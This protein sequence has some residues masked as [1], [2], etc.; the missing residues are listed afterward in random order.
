MIMPIFNKRGV[1]TLFVGG[2]HKLRWQDEVGGTGNVNFT[3]IFSHNSKLKEFLHKCQ[4]GIGR[5][6]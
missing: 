2:V 3:H 5:W 4:P 6:S 1:L